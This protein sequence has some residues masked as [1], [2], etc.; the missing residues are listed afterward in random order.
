M[1]GVRDDGALEPERLGTQGLPVG[2]GLADRV[3]V[4]ERTT[5]ALDEEED[6]RDGQDREDGEEAPA[7][8][9]AP[10]RRRGRALVGH[11]RRRVG[12]WVRFGGGAGHDRSLWAGALRRPMAAPTSEAPA[13]RPS[14]QRPGRWRRRTAFP[15]RWRSR[16][17]RS[18]WRISRRATRRPTS[19]VSSLQR[20][21]SETSSS[22]SP[23]ASCSTSTWYARRAARRRPAKRRRSRAGTSTTWRATRGSGT[24]VDERAPLVEGVPPVDREVHDRDVDGDE[25]AATAHRRARRPAPP[26]RGAGP[27]TRFRGARAAR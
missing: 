24:R 9:P 6:E 10:G 11:G 22:W 4:V 13:P 1:N 3:E 5:Q 7:D 17:R 15:A 2:E 27:G 26:A 18:S 25:H 23:T 8:P 12:R 14:A 21:V 20:S 19:S 16:R